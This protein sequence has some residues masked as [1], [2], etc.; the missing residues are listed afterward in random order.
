MGLFQYPNT[1][2]CSV[3]PDNCPSVAEMDKNLCGCK[4]D[5][6]Y[7]G[8]SFVC[9]PTIIFSYWPWF[10]SHKLCDDTKGD[11]DCG[12]Q[13]HGVK[14]INESEPYQE[15]ISQCC[16]GDAS[17][18]CVVSIL[19]F[20]LN[21]WSN[22]ANTWHALRT[23]LLHH[24]CSERHRLQWR[25]Q[26]FRLWRQKTV[27]RVH[28]ECRGA[29]SFSN[30]QHACINIPSALSCPDEQSL[31]V[32]ARHQVCGVRMCTCWRTKYGM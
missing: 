10:T 15:T 3:I 14:D 29:W 28:G 30:H 22:I 16:S 11:T 19:S 4:T 27:S 17:S 23:E 20:L 18:P 7:C 13:R 2:A 31:Q 25:I 5:G 24:N 26:M 12:H 6:C 32:E 8:V 9:F 1:L 21:P